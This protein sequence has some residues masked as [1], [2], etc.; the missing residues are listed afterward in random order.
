[1]SARFPFFALALALASTGCVI[2]TDNLP[3]VGNNDHELDTSD[4]WMSPEEIEAGTTMLVEIWDNYG[5]LDFRDL[6][7]VREL[8]DFS[9]T[10]WTGYE[11]HA[12]MVIEVSGN[13]VGEQVLALDFTNGTV[14][15]SFQAL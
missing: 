10:E 9:V 12:D 6:S 5:N 4:P 7:S 8:G 11:D 13:A 2:H 15:T 1:M 3:G 14:Y